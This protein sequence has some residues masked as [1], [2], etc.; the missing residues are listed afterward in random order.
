MASLGGLTSVSLAGTRGWQG[1]LHAGAGLAMYAHLHLGRDCA[2]IEDL[3]CAERCGGIGHCDPAEY[4]QFVE[5]VGWK[6]GVLGG[7]VGW[8]FKQ[9]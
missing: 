9:E 8:S 5:A 6:E 7:C 3:N 2:V 4:R 1:D